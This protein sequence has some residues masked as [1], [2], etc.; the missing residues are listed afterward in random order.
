MNIK[1]LKSNLLLKDQDIDD[2]ENTNYLIEF[3]V[4]YSDV[5]ELPTL[6]FLI[7]KINEGNR[8]V[9]FEEF[10]T[11]FENSKG[12]SNEFVSKNYEISKTVSIK[13]LLNFYRIIHLMGWFTIICI[14]VGL[15]ICYKKFTQMK[16]VIHLKMEIICYCCG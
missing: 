3:N 11:V 9:S 15:I 10:K 5:Y 12:F 14:Y 16:I 7:Y 4:I 13:H 8:L 2:H 6:Y 1:Y